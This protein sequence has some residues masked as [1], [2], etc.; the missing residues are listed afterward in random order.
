MWQLL[1]LVQAIYNIYNTKYLHSNLHKLL[2]QE[3]NKSLCFLMIK[4]I[5]ICVYRS[6]KYLQSG[7]AIQTIVQSKERLIYLDLRTL[8]GQALPLSHL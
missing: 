1:N 7:L 3:F 8:S 6:I 2:F 5:G 4:Q